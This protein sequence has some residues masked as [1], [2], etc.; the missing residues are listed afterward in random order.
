MKKFITILLSGLIISCSTDDDFEKNENKNFISNI[1]INLHDEEYWINYEETDFTFEYDRLNRLIKKNGGLSRLPNSA[2]FSYAFTKDIHTNLTYENNK[3]T[4]EDF[5]SIPTKKRYIT[6]NSLQKIESIEI[7][8]LNR[9]MEFK[10]SDNKLTEILT[11]FIK[12][13]F[14]DNS[15]IVSFVE[16]FYYDSNDNLSRTEY[17]N[18]EPNNNST[19]KIVRI[20]KDYDNSTNPTKSLYLLEEYFYRSISKNNYRKYEKT[21][22][23]GEYNFRTSEKTWFFEYDSKGNIILDKLQQL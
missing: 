15:L 1:K 2:G 19:N 17:Y 6:L 8:H 3:V 13:P 4:V 16:K 9:R 7:P 11:L 21:E 22:Y 12:S 10:Y 20:F 5:S 23:Y 14:N 18:N